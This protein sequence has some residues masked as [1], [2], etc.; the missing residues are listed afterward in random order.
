MFLEALAAGRGSKER[1][2]YIFR[3][4]RGENG[5]LPPNDWISLFGGP[6]GSV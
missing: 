6:A 4:G 5:E 3:E 1:D 2:R